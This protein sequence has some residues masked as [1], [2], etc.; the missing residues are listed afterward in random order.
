MPVKIKQIIIRTVFFLLCAAILIATPVLVAFKLS[1]KDKEKKNFAVLTLWQIDSFEGGK[2]SRAGYLQN[3]GNRFAEEGGCYVNVVALTSAAAIENLAAGAV[4]DLISYGAGM[5]GIETLI[6]GKKPYTTWAHGGYC[7]LSV[8]ESADFS[9]IN[10]ENTVVNC[11]TENLAGAAA[12]LCGIKG[13]ATDKPTGAYVSLIN[14]NFKYLLGTQRDIYRLK[15]RGADFK[16]K[17][18][19]EFNDLYQNIS[20]TAKNSEKFFYGEKFVDYLMNCNSELTKLGLMCES[21]LYDDEMSQLEGVNYET[22]L[23]SPVGESAKNEILQ[24]IENSDI[25]KL[26]SF[27]K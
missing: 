20:V 7:F 21:K 14:G 3:I 19:T 26:K 2:G 22:R 23:V 13:A 10:T 18:V 11:G 24:A 4:P 27:L 5:C 8:D 16:V 9:D 17:A 12:L 15:T 25:K 6:G 1:D